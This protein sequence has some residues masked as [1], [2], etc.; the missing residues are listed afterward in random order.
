AL[1]QYGGSIANRFSRRVSHQSRNV[2]PHRLVKKFLNNQTRSDSFQKGAA[3]FD[4]SRAATVA[5]GEPPSTPGNRSEASS[6]AVAIRHS[7][8]L[9][10]LPLPG[11]ASKLAPRIPRPDSHASQFWA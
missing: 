10:L 11:V 5:T 8:R 2:T 9:P 1:G 7:V 6:H 4:A 3:G